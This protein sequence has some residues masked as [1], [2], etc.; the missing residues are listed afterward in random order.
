M[1]STIET[2]QETVSQITDYSAENGGGNNNRGGNNNGGNNAQIGN[3][4]ENNR[5]NS[6]KFGG[7]TRR[8]GAFYCL[9][10]DRVATTKAHD[11]NHV[12][13]PTKTNTMA[14]I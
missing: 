1:G 8:R 6:G 14:R 5:S 9:A 10:K 7:S 11:M 12:P 4:S 13:N 2:L 3:G